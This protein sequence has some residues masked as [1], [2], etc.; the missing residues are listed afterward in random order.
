M[1]R[2]TFLRD[3]AAAA[4]AAGAGRTLPATATTLTEAEP[5]LQGSLSGRIVDAHVH[6]LDTAGSLGPF[7]T[8]SQP[9]HLLKWMDACGVD[10]AIMLPYVSER[11]PDNNE[12]CAGL[13][14]QHPDRLVTLTDVRLHETDAVEQVSRAREIYG[15][16]G[17][18]YYPPKPGLGWLAE[19][20]R[21]SLWEAYRANDLVCNLQVT[22]ADY[23]TMLQLC[24]RYPDIRFVLNHLAL[25]GSLSPADTDYGGLLDAAA[26]PNLFVKASGFYACADQPWDLHDARA[27]GFLRQLVGGLGAERVLWGS[28][29]PP[30]GWHLTYRQAL[31]IV[32][33]AV[34]FSPH[35]LAMILESN[36]ATV[37]RV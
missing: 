1:K 11:T 15:A 26:Y 5:V 3:S 24:R 17:I 22:P 8:M 36:A 21:E 13:A 37:Y 27:L 4:L 31:E 10:T 2:R 14:R 28:D 16:A 34:G 29:W 23:T 12:Y 18:S 6:V 7:T 35:E 9:G 20:A 30:V 33:S 19:S 32:R 25:P